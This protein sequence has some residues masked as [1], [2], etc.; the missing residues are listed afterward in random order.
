MRKQWLFMT[1]LMLTLFKAFAQPTVPA[2]NPP[3]RNAGDV[4]S[5]FS[6]SYTNVSGIDWFP[7]WGQS[8][9]VADFTVLGNVTKRYT[10][11]NYQGVQFSSPVNASSMT[12]LHVDIWTANCTAF[13]I[14]LI[15][16]S[17]VLFE[18]KVTL[19]PTF[20]G[21]NSYDIPLTQFTGVALSNIG[22]MKL[23]G[24][25]AGSSVVYLDNIYFW[26]SSNIPTITGFSIPEKFIGNAPFTI[27][28]PTS[29]STGA[30][31]YTSSNTSVATVSGNTVTILAAGTSTIT[32]NQAAAAPYSAGSATTTLLVSY[33]PPAAAAP[34][35]PTRAVGDYV[36]LYSDAYTNV[37]PIDWN[38]F[39]GQ[40]TI[41]SEVQIAANPTRKY[42][43]L[44]YQ[45]VQF[46][47]PLNVASM[48]RLHVDI[49]TP[50]CT[51]FEL[52]LINTTP[53]TVEQRVTLNPTLSGWNS[54]DIPLTSFSLVNLSNVAQIKLIG[55]PSGSSVVYL[56]NIY[57]WKSSS[58]PT[59]TGFSVPAKTLG[60]APFALTAPTSNST[61]AFTYTSSNPAVASI[62]GNIVTVIGV[63]TS[64]IT[65]NQ[66]AAGA[67]TS[68][69]VTSPLVVSFPPPAIAAPTPPI[70]NAP[71]YISVFSDAYTNLAGTDFFPTWG[72][73]TVVSEVSIAGNPT[74]KYTNLNFQGIQL[75][76]PINVANMQFLHLD[77]WTPNLTAFDVFLINTTPA[78]VQQ[79]VTLT[80]TLSGWN[81]F[82]IPLT[83]YTSIALS[84][85]AQLMFEGLPSGSG[86]FHMD[87]LYFWK[88]SNAPTLSNF[89][90]PAKFFGN[91]PFAITAPTSNS[92]GAFT[93]TS[94][95]PSVATISGSTITITGVGTSI[96]TANQAAAG[97]YSAGSIAA[98]F[99]VSTA[100]PPTAAP[101]PPL[102]NAADVKCMFSNAYT[103]IAGTIWFPNWGQTTVVSDISIF[104][105]A[106]K[107]YETTN[108]QGVELASPINI[109]AM[110]KLHIDLWTPNCN[111]LEFYLLN[112]FPVT[113]EEK[114]ILRPTF[115]GWNSFDIDLAQFDTI[116]K[117]AVSQF[118]MVATP[119]GTST[120]FMDNMYFW[121]PA[122]TVPVTLKTFTAAK[123]GKTTLLEWVTSSEINN[124]GFE[125]E[126]SKDGLQWQ[127][128]KFVPGFGN[129]STERK[130]GTVDP[131]PFKGINFYRLKQID[132]D[133]RV[134][135]SN[136]QK[137]NFDNSAITTLDIYPNPVNDV[138]QFRINDEGINQ[139]NVVLTDMQGKI[140]KTVKVNNLQSGSFY[141]ISTAQIPQGMYL[142]KYDNGR[143]SL[144][145]KCI[146]VH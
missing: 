135:L 53:A 2:T 104:G 4:I 116:N 96:I 15:N 37:S 90:I 16:T 91:A 59:I 112:T 94:S 99:S 20:S 38:P 50:N 17:P 146:I 129:S 60:D 131:A 7:N 92:T 115:S 89:T 75:Q 28:A 79:K 123:N 141:Q 98:T 36:S 117:N 68:G 62:S 119:F 83:Q 64:T 24:T 85:V 27:T 69:S 144:V 95:N 11:L 31:T 71:D 74:K 65:A 35:P 46:G 23:V 56:D 140:I 101:V 107:K 41:V 97:A 143:N 42:T 108:Y 139:A 9:V 134:N 142:L 29:N 109:S 84:N 63:G 18:R 122:G 8:T 67:Y 118:K 54:F 13:D 58:S 76:T 93:Y 49:W 55:T 133:G 130:Y 6:G 32:A 126:K 21:W 132:F 81:S 66:A 137:V 121:K 40:S 128:L 1:V 34:T 14:F 103:E 106:T 72:Q 22:Q 82:N 43:N 25:P 87:N 125:V 136:I 51:A 39:W 5:L 52:Y 45:G 48:S 3:T 80:P 111:T 30:F 19:N 110:T 105:N 100:P 102:R 138:L 114:V 33:P 78:T 113:V 77:V 120:L 61:G 124:S 127:V 26:K 44:N 88:S 57:F 10:N 70:R 12:N 86:T 145:R 47:T 73:T